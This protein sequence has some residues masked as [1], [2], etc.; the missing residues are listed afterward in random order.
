M[1]GVAVAGIDG[2]VRVP[3]RHGGPAHLRHARG[4]GALPAGPR[5]GLPAVRAAGEMWADIQGFVRQTGKRC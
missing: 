3:E 5:P 4:G 1:T 2:R